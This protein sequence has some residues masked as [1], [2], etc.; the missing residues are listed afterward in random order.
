MAAALASHS[1]LR[2]CSLVELQLVTHSVSSESSAPC[3]AGSCWPAGLGARGRQC[4]AADSTQFQGEF[5]NEIKVLSSLSHSHVMCVCLLGYA[6]EGGERCIVTPYF[7]H[8]SLQA[9]LAPAWAFPS[10]QRAGACLDVVTGLTY[11]HEQKIWPFDLKPG[12]SI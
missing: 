5:L 1:G 7:P 3:T 11:L 8:G 2:V 12:G 10:L 6:S 4:L 9:A